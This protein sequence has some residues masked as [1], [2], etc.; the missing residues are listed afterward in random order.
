LETFEGVT[1]NRVLENV[2]GID[3]TETVYYEFLDANSMRVATLYNNEDCLDDGEEFQIIYIDLVEN[4]PDYFK[5]TF[6]DD[7]E[8]RG[9]RWPEYLD[10]NGTISEIYKE[11]SYELTNWLPSGCN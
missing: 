10:V 5:F 3:F 6:G 8:I 4:N 9:Y 2:N 1:E 7:F 11:Q